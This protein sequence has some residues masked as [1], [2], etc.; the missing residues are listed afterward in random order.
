M[1]RN[2]VLLHKSPLAK[3]KAHRRKLAKYQERIDKC[4]VDG[5]ELIVLDEGHKIK[6]VDSKISEAICKVKTPRRC[7]LTGKIF[8]DRKI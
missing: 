8:L 7:I 2:L 1:F 4:L 6:N 5:V 3:N